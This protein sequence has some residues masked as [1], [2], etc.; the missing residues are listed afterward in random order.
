M[1]NVGEHW[2]PYSRPSVTVDVVVFDGDR[3]LLI[4]RRD[5]PFSGKWAL[6]GGFVDPDELTEDAACRE[7]AEECGLVARRPA[8]PTSTW[9]N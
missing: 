5:D 7:L 3:I 6:P 9:S 2:Y 1:S 8:R 4:E